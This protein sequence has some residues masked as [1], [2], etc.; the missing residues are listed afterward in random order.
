M[1]PSK[2]FIAV[3]ERSN[4]AGI[5]TVY[6]HKKSKDIRIKKKRTF[7]STDLGN[8]SFVF[9]RFLP[10]NEKYLIALTEAPEYKL[11][12]WEWEKGKL[13]SVSPINGFKNINGLF[14]PED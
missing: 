3:A 6:E 13:R 12:L 5:I 8:K 7:L 10:Q 9:L 1:S 11:C 4:E 2:N 14:F